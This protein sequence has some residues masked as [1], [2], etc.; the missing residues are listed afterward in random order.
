MSYHE[1]TVQ[2]YNLKDQDAKDLTNHIK[3]I[4]KGFFDGNVAFSVL[5]K[6]NRDVISDE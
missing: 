3:N 5:W 1:F 4:L 2:M 6:I